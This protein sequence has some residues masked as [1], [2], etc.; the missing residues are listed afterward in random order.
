MNGSI[1]ARGALPARGE[2]KFVADRR[3][4]RRQHRRG[5]LD[6]RHADAPVFAAGEIAAGAVDRIDDPDQLLAEARFVVGAF[7]RQPAIVRRG[8]IAAASRSD[9]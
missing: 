6:Q 4:H 3:E 9:R 5:I 8:A 1:V 7:F 2:K